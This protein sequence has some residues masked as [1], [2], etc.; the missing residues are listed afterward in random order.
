MS[1]SKD[2]SIEVFILQLRQLAWCRHLIKC[3]EELLD[4]CEPTTKA[5]L[6]DGLRNVED[7]W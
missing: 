6:D 7:E 4:A 5:M 1:Q 3:T 2:A